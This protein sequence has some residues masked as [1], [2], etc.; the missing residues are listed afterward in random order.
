MMCQY[1]SAGSYGISCSKRCTP[2][3]V[4]CWQP[5]RMLR[6]FRSARGLLH[7]LSS[8]NAHGRDTQF[9]CMVQAPVQP[10]CAQLVT[11][12]SMGITARAALRPEGSA[13]HAGAALL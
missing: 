8:C 9:I 2:P 4:I 1:L 7:R 6:R 12:G 13:A 10:Y 5:G 11:P 3:A